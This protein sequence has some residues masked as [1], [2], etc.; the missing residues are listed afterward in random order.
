LTLSSTS[1]P[2]LP[3]SFTKILIGHFKPSFQY[4]FKIS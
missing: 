4:L 1:T 2:P 3:V